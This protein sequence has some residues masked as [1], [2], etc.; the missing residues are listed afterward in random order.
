MFLLLTLA[1]LKTTKGN[2]LY[3]QPLKDKVCGV[4]STSQYQVE[5]GEE[6]KEYCVLGIADHSMA[7]RATLYAISKK[8][9]LA[10]VRSVIVMNYKHKT[11]PTEGIIISLWRDLTSTS[12]VGKCLCFT[13]VVVTSFNEETRRSD[14]SA[15]KTVTGLQEDTTPVEGGGGGELG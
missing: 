4:S 13:D 10:D 14:T 5:S 7:M 11:E 12:R 9:N 3:S 6:K 8:A 15:T 1:K 2:K